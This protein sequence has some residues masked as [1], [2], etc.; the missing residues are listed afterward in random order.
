MV[1]NNFSNTLFWYVINV[2]LCRQFHSNAK[3]PDAYFHSKIYFNI[4]F[5]SWVVMESQKSSCSW[6]AE[7]RIHIHVFIHS[8]SVL[9]DTSWK[10]YSYYMHHLCLRSSRIQEKS[11]S[12]LVSSGQLTL[13][14]RRN[15]IC[16]KWI[17][18]VQY[19]DDLWTAFQNKI[20][21][22]II[23]ESQRATAYSYDNN[24]S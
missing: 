21:A 10:Y 8:G 22:I 5:S 7:T 18:E 1:E 16:F 14:L 12:Q 4:M 23:S 9:A 2:K 15:N 19:G 6:Y 13:E 17:P 11:A 20:A 3:L 24:H